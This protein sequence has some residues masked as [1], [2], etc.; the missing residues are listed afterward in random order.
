MLNRKI[1]TFGLLPEC[2]DWH[3]QVHVYLVGGLHAC[4][5]HVSCLHALELPDLCSPRQV[6]ECKYVYISG[7]RFII[8]TFD[9][10][11]LISK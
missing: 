4:S 6:L 11:L 7:L 5:P 9:S 8:L 1:L 2:G 3:P 10:W